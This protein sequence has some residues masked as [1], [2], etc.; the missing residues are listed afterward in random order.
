MLVNYA[1][2]REI[3]CQVINREIRK[4]GYS[5]REDQ[6]SFERILSQDQYIL[7][8]ALLFIVVVIVVMK[9]H[10]QSNCKFGGKKHYQLNQI[11]SLIDTYSIDPRRLK[12]KLVLVEFKL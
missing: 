10:E 6:R 5:S 9:I 2:R 11:Q 3:L 4:R 7:L 12:G 1:L 8:E